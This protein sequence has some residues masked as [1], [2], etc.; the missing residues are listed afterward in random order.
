MYGGLK[1]N[2]GNILLIP[3]LTHTLTQKKVDQQP[4]PV[5][6]LSIFHRVKSTSKGVY[7]NKDTT[8]KKEQQD[9]NKKLTY[10]MF[11]DHILKTETANR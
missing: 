11:L 2:R 9:G 1:K 10:D 5:G 4:G 3:P 7:S 8:Y 6:Q